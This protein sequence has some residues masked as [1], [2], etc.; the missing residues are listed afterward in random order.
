MSL[1]NSR[2]D[3][4]AANRQS[5]KA[6]FGV[7]SLESKQ[8]LSGATQS[9]AHVALPQTVQVATPAVV[10]SAPSQQTQGGGIDGLFRGRGE[11]GYH[12]HTVSSTGPDSVNPPVGAAG[13]TT[14]SSDFRRVVRGYHHHAVSSTGPESVNTPTAAGTVSVADSATIS[15]N[16]RIITGHHPLPKA[17]EPLNS[18]GRTM[19]SADQRPGRHWR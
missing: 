13:P 5:R 14:I 11:G 18:A 12:H 2:N 6:G 19:I 10:S 4:S 16:G 9:L 3:K 17:A 1:F 7:E 8:L 15:A